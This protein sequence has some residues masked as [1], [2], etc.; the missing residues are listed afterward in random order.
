MPI[1]RLPDHRQ[2][3]QHPPQGKETNLTFPFRDQKPSGRG[4]EEKQAPPVFQKQ[5]AKKKTIN[6]ISAI[7]VPFPRIT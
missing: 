6:E 5:E 7:H 4:K 1:L 3:G 2:I